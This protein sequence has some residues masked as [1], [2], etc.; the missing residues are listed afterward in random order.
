MSERAERAECERERE[1][2]SQLGSR[3]SSQHFREKGQP[4]DP[5]VPVTTDFPVEKWDQNGLE[6][7]GA[8]LRFLKNT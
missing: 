3:V 6:K 1:A 4:G 5:L 2:A 7:R 8:L